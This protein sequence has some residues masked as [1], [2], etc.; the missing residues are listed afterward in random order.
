MTKGKD[1]V[2]LNYI[3]SLDMK[4]KIID[5][6][7]VVSFSLAKD[8]NTIVMDLKWYN[9]VL[10][11]HLIDHMT[12]FSVAVFIH[13]KKKEEIIGNIFKMWILLFAFPKKILSDNGG[14]FNNKHL[15]EL[16][17]LLNTCILCTSAESP[18]SNGI[19][20][21]HVI[22]G[23]MVDKVIK[24]VS[25]SVIVA[26]AWSVSAKDSLKNVHGYSPNQLVFGKNP[27]FPVV[28]ENELPALEITK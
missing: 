18:W 25:C 22:I 8:F 21:R 27:D 3:C 17:Q 5:H 14:E 7:P 23:N 19:T 11:L 15:H 12:R 2:H 9:G 4:E 10:C 1:K 26:L 16:G 24:D 13:T 20:E 6:R 28:I